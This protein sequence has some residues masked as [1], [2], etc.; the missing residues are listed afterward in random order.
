[1]NIKY[2]LTG[3]M[4]QMEKPAFP[5]WGSKWL[6]YNIKFICC[7]FIAQLL[8]IL[9]A[10]SK[11]NENFNFIMKLAGMLQA[12]FLAI[13]LMNIIYFIFPTLEFLLF[14]RFNILFRKYTFQ[15]LN[16]INL[17]IPIFALVIVFVAKA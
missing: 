4:N 5:W 2:F 7:L 17:I 16:I 13:I 10:I 15:F 14:R 8:F 11:S 12:D 6:E 9:V 3:P 1:M